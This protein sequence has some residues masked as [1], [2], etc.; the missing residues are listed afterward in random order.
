MQFLA[1]AISG[2]WLRFS[3][4]NRAEKLNDWSFIKLI[5]NLNAFGLMLKTTV[6][7]IREIILYVIPYP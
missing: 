7:T 1:K 6:H 2:E 3:L 4:K 5:L